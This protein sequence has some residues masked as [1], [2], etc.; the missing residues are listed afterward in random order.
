MITEKNGFDYL[1]T[2]CG[3]KWIPSVERG[4]PQGSSKGIPIAVVIDEQVVKTFGTY[5]PLWEAMRDGTL[6][7]VT[8]NYSFPEA[9]S[10]IDI[11]INGSTVYTLHIAEPLMAAAMASNPTL[12]EITAENA[13]VST[14]WSYVSGSFE[15]PAI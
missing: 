7:D 11:N 12:V 13:N 9:E 3:W 8:S 5:P 4:L 1:G 10:V 2:D 14:G 15:E 6:V